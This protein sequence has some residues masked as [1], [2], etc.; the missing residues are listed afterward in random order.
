[1]P[2]PIIIRQVQ[3]RHSASAYAPETDYTPRQWV[4]QPGKLVAKI[5]FWGPDHPSW[6]IIRQEATLPADD[7]LVTPAVAPAITPTVAGR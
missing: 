6:D 5:T 1:M 4:Q 7:K 3:R 2:T